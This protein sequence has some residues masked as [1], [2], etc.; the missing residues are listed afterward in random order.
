MGE[1]RDDG[2]RRRRRSACSTERLCRV[3]ELAIA[4]S[5][6]EETLSELIR[7]V[8]TT[9]AHRRARLD[10]AARR[11]PPSPRRGAEPAAAPIAMR[12]TGPRSARSR[13]RAGPRPFAASRCSS[14]TS[15][16]ILCGRNS[17]RSRCPHGLRAVL[18]DADHH[19]RIQGAGHLRHVPSRAARSDGARP[20]AGR[21]RHAHRGPGHRPQAR[22]GSRRPDAA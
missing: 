7:I 5:P 14:P 9:L 11:P 12:S 21:S 2:L 15:R 10:P 4:N 19:R 17:R 13:D 1:V 8:E 6:L 20:G 16:P 22:P 3:L 18:V